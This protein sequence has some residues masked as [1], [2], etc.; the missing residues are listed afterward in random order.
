[1]EPL[2]ELKPSIKGSIQHLID[3]ARG[4]SHEN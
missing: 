2:S 1:M 3:D 4:N